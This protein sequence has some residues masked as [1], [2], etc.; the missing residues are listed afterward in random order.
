MNGQKGPSPYNKILSGGPL[1]RTI[2]TEH[3]TRYFTGFGVAENTSGDYLSA[4]GE[5]LGQLVAGHVFW[6]ASDIEVSAFD[7]VTAWPC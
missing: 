7:T 6:Q 4:W 1:V 5:Q 3:Y 2:S